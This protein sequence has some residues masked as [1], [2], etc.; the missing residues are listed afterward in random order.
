MYKTLSRGICSSK[1]FL[2]SS[3]TTGI[4]CIC[5]VTWVHPYCRRK[6]T[7]LNM[8]FHLCLPFFHMAAVNTRDWICCSICTLIFLST[9]FPHR[10]YSSNYWLPSRGCDSSW[11]L[12]SIHTLLMVSHYA[13]V[14]WVSYFG[15]RI[16]AT[17]GE[18][19]SLFLLVVRSIV[20]STLTSI[21]ELI[22]VQGT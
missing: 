2:A 14:Y 10:K 19:T 13:R 22:L 20:C 16:N 17:C 15:Y 9:G 7:D 21:G 12:R 5:F 8:L 4:F 18:I 1:V 3:Y 6:Y 11:P